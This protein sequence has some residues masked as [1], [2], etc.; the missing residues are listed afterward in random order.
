MEHRFVPVTEDHIL[1][2]SVNM[3]Q[4]D[5]DNIDA[6]SG[7]SPASGLRWSLGY[8]IDAKTWLVG[9]RV[10]AICGLGKLTFFSESASPWLIGTDLIRK[11]PKVFYKE[12][13]RL[14]YDALDRHRCLITYVDARNKRSI[15][16]LKHT[17]FTIHP[18]EPV[19]VKQL[20]FHLAE[21][22]K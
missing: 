16:W 9:D 12:H 21:L 1:E 15:R 7:M 2:L 14:I 11:Y 17:G 5:I 13:R 8:S 10:A 4:S 19:G 20:P 3:Q 6:I 18:A 22:R